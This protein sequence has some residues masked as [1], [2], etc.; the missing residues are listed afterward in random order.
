MSTDTLAFFHAAKNMAYGVEYPV[1][2]A[3][4]PVHAMATGRISVH[5]ILLPYASCLTYWCH[6]FW[7]ILVKFGLSIPKSGQKLKCFIGIL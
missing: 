1:A 5:L 4:K 6:P 3:K 7:A 2:A